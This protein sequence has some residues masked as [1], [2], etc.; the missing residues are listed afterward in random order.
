MPELTLRRVEPGR[1]ALDD[2]GT[3]RSMRRFAA[4]IEARGT[5]WNLRR[6]ALGLGQIINATDASTGERVA[7]YVPSGRLHLRGIY[8]G[9]IELDGRELDWQANHRMGTHFTAREDGAKLAEFDA[10]SNELPVTVALFGWHHLEAL[11][12]LFCCHIV[13]QIVDMTLEAGTLGPPRVQ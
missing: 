11:P 8:G 1:Y 12:L 3:L 10:G 13:K 4:D 5:V 6:T 7:R 9:T 2:L